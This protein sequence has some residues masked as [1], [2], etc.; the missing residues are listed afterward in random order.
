[1]ANKAKFGDLLEVGLRKIFDDNFKEYPEQYSKLFKVNSSTKQSETDTAVT[2][3]GLM[4]EHT[5][6]EP[7]KYEDVLQGDDVTYTHKTF[8]KGFSVSKDLFED[9]QYNVI[10]KKP[11]ALA[12][13]ARRT[14][15]YYAAGVF[16]NAF[17]T[18]YQGGDGYP[19]CSTLHKSTESEQAVQSNACATGTVLSEDNLKTAILAMRRQKD[20][21]GMKIQI[22]PTTL[23]VSPT[24]EHTARIILDS[25]LR[26]GTANNDANTLKGQLD[27][28]VYDWLTS[29]TA[30][31]LIDKNQHELNFFWRVKPSFNQDES[32][33]TDAALYKARMRF[34]CGFSD[35]RG[36]WGSKGDAGAYSS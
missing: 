32:F 20:D 35:W 8:K 1:M 6:S 12:K 33:D 2:G 21:K 5:E 22:Q 7:L 15:E 27:V 31:F 10:K 19:L 4:E 17:S 34:S 25:Q 36:V 24:L 30:W 16:N 29:T 23:V 14:V 13:S 18:S 26:S 28:V 9:D 3:F 11:A